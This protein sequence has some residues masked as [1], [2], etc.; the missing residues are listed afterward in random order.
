MSEKFWEGEEQNVR[1]D[2]AQVK[3]RQK[4]FWNS[5]D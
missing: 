3:K 2:L 5:N 4:Y 1:N